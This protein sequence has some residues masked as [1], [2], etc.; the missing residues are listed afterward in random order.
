VTATWR[1]ILTHLKVRFLQKTEKPTWKYEAILLIIFPKRGGLLSSGR[2]N[3]C[4]IL[5][6]IPA[7]T[8]IRGTNK[9]TPHEKRELYKLTDIEEDKREARSCLI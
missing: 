8:T 4:Q 5:L 9:K 3:V 7:M 6:D 2:K 1:L